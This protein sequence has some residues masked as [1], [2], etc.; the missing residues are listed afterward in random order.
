MAKVSPATYLRQVR[1]EVEKI[2]WPSR[3]ETALSTVMVIVMV[4]LM[5]LFFF[6]V[7]QVVGLAV[8]GILGIGG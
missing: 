2:T 7:D 4:I 1:Q 6:V 3:K 5:A 8:R